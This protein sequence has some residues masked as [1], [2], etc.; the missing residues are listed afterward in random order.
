M[1]INETTVLIQKVSYVNVNINNIFLFD[2]ENIL[3]DLKQCSV[4]CFSIFFR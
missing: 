4:M 2:I 1:E 3:N